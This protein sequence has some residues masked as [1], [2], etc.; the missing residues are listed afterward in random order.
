MRSHTCIS[1]PNACLAHSNSFHY[2]E[3]LCNPCSL[4]LFTIGVNGDRSGV[5]QKH[6]GGARGTEGGGVVTGGEEFSTVSG[7]PL[8]RF[9]HTIQMLLFY[10]CSRYEK[11]LRCNG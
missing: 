11:P 3:N 7:D 4:L 10:V 9:E 2:S 8:S 5:I 6:M 1:R